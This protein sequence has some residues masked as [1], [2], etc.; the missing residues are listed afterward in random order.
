MGDFVLYLACMSS[1]SIARNLTFHPPLSFSL[2]LSIHH[3][4]DAEVGPTTTKM[5]AQGDVN[6]ALSPPQESEEAGAS[7]GA[8]NSGDIE[9][10]SW[11]FSFLPQLLPAAL[12]AGGV[13]V[14]AVGY[15]EFVLPRTEIAAQRLY[16]APPTAAQ[17][18]AKPPEAKCVGD[19]CH[20]SLREQNEAP[21]NVCVWG[22]NVPDGQKR[23]YLQQM[24]SLPGRDFQ[25]TYFMSSE[26]AL[27]A[28]DAEGAAQSLNDYEQKL[29]ALSQDTDPARPRVKVVRS[30]LVGFAIPHS[31]LRE[32]PASELPPDATYNDIMR[33]MASRYRA[34]GGD[35]DAI[36]PAWVAAPHLKTRAALLQHACDVSVHGNI[37]GVSA[38]FLITN[39]A[40]SLGIPT[41]AE[42]LNLWVDADAA[43]DVLVG[44]SLFSVQHG[45]VSW[46][47]SARKRDQSC[48]VTP[49]P[50][51]R[52]LEPSSDVGLQLQRHACGPA[53]MVISPGVD[54]QLFDPQRQALRPALLHF[55]DAVACPPAAGCLVVAF[56]AR[57][58]SEKNPG[59]FLL[60]AH[61]ALQ[62]HPHARFVVVGGGHLSEHL[63][64][65][66]LRLGI[67]SQVYFPGWVAHDD[68][69]AL[70]RAVDIVVNPSVR[71]WSETFCIANTEAM[72]MQVP[73]VTFAAG[74][75]GQ[76]VRDPAGSSKSQADPSAEAQLQEGAFS[77]GD[78][79]VVVHEASP[80][81]LAAAVAA[82]LDDRALRERLGAAGRSTV[83]EFFRVEQQMW[84]Y[85]RLYRQLYRSSKGGK[86]GKGEGQDL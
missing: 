14:P 18:A 31:A 80:Q 54:T 76:Y 45:S 36:T 29:L 48:L 47:F 51:A 15:M 61:A 57:L 17:A 23:I 46:L 30:P 82:L 39:A 86:G 20:T 7:D 42:L 63:Q 49:L 32:P 50:L 75:V 25:F 79:A 84:Q 6:G 64:I 69:P 3:V 37:R 40:R 58:S 13:A 27:T 66:A 67:S 8:S 21:I 16:A 43:P 9:P 28:I 62:S 56:V 52:Q 10:A 71:G 65:L 78:N 22:S 5:D 83:V 24:Q 11:F 77:I 4:H 68:L 41:I 1:L 55:P 60:A 85:E 33:Y 73:L 44:P 72:A 26:S 70:F 59:L 19:T 74:G 81:A 2:L 38:E 53:S 12:Q 35:L 34:A